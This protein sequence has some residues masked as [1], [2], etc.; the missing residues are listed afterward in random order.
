MCGGSEAGLYSRLMDACITHQK[1]LLLDGCECLR[2]LLLCLFH[3]E[4]GVLSSDDV[5]QDTSARYRAVE[6]SS[7]AN[8]IPR[9]A[10]LGLAGLRPYVIL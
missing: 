10:R 2:L 1:R 7:G 3:L 4:C 6:P 5:F 8:V 9:W